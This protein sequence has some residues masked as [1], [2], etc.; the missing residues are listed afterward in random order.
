MDEWQRHVSRAFQTYPLALRNVWTIWL[1][2]HAPLLQIEFSENTGKTHN[3]GSVT[4]AEVHGIAVLVAREVD[5]Q[6]PGHFAMEQRDPLRR[7]TR[8][9]RIDCHASGHAIEQLLFCRWLELVRGILSEGTTPGKSPAGEPAFMDIGRRCRANV[10]P[11]LL[12][13]K[14]TM[15]A[16]GRHGQQFARRCRILLVTRSPSL[17]CENL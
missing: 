14:K 4:I 9:P 11:I 13:G 7:S 16:E 5:A 17:S 3:N 1:I 8:R 12:P 10:Q 6:A 2:S 15:D